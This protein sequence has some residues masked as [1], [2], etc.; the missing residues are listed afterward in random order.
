MGR[1]KKEGA[2][3]RRKRTAKAARRERRLFLLALPLALSL[4]LLLALPLALLL[5]LVETD[6]EL[7]L[8]S[9][10]EEFRE[11]TRDGDLTVHAR[12]SLPHT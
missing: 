4:A 1:G 9:C 5:A 7:S 10:A 6:R 11:G 12:A 3:T 8:H 2:V